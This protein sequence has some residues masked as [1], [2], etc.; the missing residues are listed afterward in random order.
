MERPAAVTL[1]GKPKTL[2]GPELKPGDPAPDFECVDMTLKPVNLAGTGT[3][4]R[5]FSVVPSLDTPICD[6]Q[7][8]R[9][10]D[11]WSKLSGI[12]IYTIS[13]DLPFAQNRWC[14]NF[15]VHNVK[16]LSDYLACSFGKA[17][18]TLIP[19]LRLE[20]RAMFVL[21][22][23]NVIRYVEYV[24]EVASHPDYDAVLSAV[25]QLVG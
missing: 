1:N 21:D 14:D 23:E 19:D 5:I 24:P 22:G 18:G 16:M 6:M 8:K 20:T 4:V 25:K 12:D 7:T 15:G 2:I 11:E 3:K 10:N 17:Y 13:V 9:L